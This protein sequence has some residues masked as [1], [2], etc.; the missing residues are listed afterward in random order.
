MNIL[1]SH[2]SR[3]KKEG[4]RMTQNR[5][6]L[7]E[8]FLKEAHPLSA[9]KLLKKL[10]QKRITLDPSTLYRELEFLNK[11][12]VIHE[13]QFQEKK[14][15]FELS[16]KKHHH[17]LYCL[18]CEHIEEVEMEGEL[19]QIEKKLARRSRFKIQSHRLEFFGL[20]ARC[21]S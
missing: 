6:A 18:K 20:C 1:E 5:V 12:N 19:E 21:T 7:L 10:K 17:H 16:F 3:W 15:H 2:L 8:L 4:Y 9:E 14:R 13:V 11:E